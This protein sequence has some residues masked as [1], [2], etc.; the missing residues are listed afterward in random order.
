MNNRAIQYIMRCQI[1]ALLVFCSILPTDCDAQQQKPRPKLGLV[2]SGGGAKGLAHIGVLR[3]LEE[4][5]LTP[6]YI[7]GTSIGSI[8]GAMYAMGYNADEIEG[9]VAGVDWDAVL[10]NTIQLNQITYEEKAY[11]G[12]YIAELPVEGT[13]VSLPKGLIDGQKL[14]EYLSR[15]T[16]PAH[17]IRNFHDLPIPFACVAADITTGEPV[18][19][20]KGS[21]PR[22]LRAS[23]AIPTFFTP[24]VI[25]STLL[26]DGGLV[27][28]FPVEEVRQMG[29]DVV[30][31]V[32]ASSYLNP[33]EKLSSFISFLS[34][35][36]FMTSAL[37]SKRQRELVDIYI[38]PELEEHSSA[39]FKQWREIIDVGAVCGKNHLHALQ[40]L[41]D[42]LNAFGP[43][44]TIEKLPLRDSFLISEITVEGA[45][46]DLSELIESRL[47]IKE[48]I[49]VG[50][51]D[52]EKGI[53]RVF[54]TRLFDK[55]EYE[56][57]QMDKGYWLKISVNKA[58]SGQLGLAAH[59]DSENDVGLNAILTYRNLLLPQSRALLEFDLSKSPRLDINYL[60]YLGRQRNFGVQIGYEY[61]RTE[62]PIYDRDI[63]T[64][65]FGA[66]YSDI[67]VQLQ[68]TAFQNFTIG[69]KGLSEHS[70][71][72]PKVGEFAL[73][74]DEIKN[75]N[76]SAEAFFRYHSLN[77][78]FFPTKGMVLEAAIKRAFDVKNRYIS[79]TDATRSDELAINQQLDPFT[80]LEL[81]YTQAFP[82]N[83]KL[84]LISKNRMALT[85]LG[86]PDFNISDYYFI[87]GF[88]PRTRNASEYWGLRQKR[89]IAPNYF[90]SRLTLQWEI[91][92]HFY[93][94][95]V[96]NYI[97][98]QYPME[99]LY[100]ITVDD[101]LDGYRRRFGY[102]FCV[103]YES[104]LGP[105]SLSF[106]NDFKS[107]DVQVNLNV[108]FW[109]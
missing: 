106:A 41:A 64:S 103:G 90:Y 80:S 51:G 29:A 44:R 6:D 1:V 92:D 104:F 4:A 5:G 69:I 35:S 60:K 87:G 91:A 19:L 27:R 59:F 86:P 40:A 21:L 66:Q 98:V 96:A 2:L 54:G 30:I 58:A 108:G 48:G 24:V 70:K 101:Y 3:A 14:S 82:I 78:P 79:F 77:K 95:G 73:L 34:Q 18:L 33:K 55:L 13:R 17:H 38:E 56:L 81:Q 102:G 11:Y 31:G 45:G 74:V 62:L 61:T 100:S 85:T 88:N 32:Y 89:F 53:G 75:R 109:Y 97:D 37:D 9:I 52:I 83:P 12:R 36:A 42:S 65:R 105:I 16:L 84:C 49:V 93:L 22:A 20:S 46:K 8:V 43:P 107:E 28:N 26:V 23:M 10:S 72:R 99:L 15:L 39:A 67:Y 76:L 25:D 47:K 68:T 63:E 57:I 71:L 7:T 94:S 50:V